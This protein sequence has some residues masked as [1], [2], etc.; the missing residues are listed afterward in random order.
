MTD[1]VNCIA[2]KNVLFIAISLGV[3]FLH[4][5]N[6]SSHANPQTKLFLKKGERCLFGRGVYYIF[7]SNL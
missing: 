6:Y 2:T 3:H 5:V 4:S 1:F 7:Y